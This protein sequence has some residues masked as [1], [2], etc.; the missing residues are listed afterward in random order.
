[1]DFEAQEPVRSTGPTGVRPLADTGRESIRESERMTTSFCDVHGCPAM[2]DNHWRKNICLETNGLRSQMG[3]RFYGNSILE[4]LVFGSYL[5]VRSVRV[6]KMLDNPCGQP[7]NTRLGK[8]LRRPGSRV[9]PCLQGV[10]RQ[11]RHPWSA[12]RV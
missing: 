7:S 1:M 5:C 12:S 6:V 4:V 2:L 9:I 11:R 10:L 3:F 8:R